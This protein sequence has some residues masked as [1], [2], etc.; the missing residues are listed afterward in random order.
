MTG[1][2]PSGAADLATLGLALL[3][4]FSALACAIT[5]IL[6]AEKADEGRR[7]KR[8]MEAA[9]MVPPGV[10]DPESGIPIHDSGIVIPPARRVRERYAYAVSID[11]EAAS[12][13]E[14]LDAVLSALPLHYEDSNGVT[15]TDVAHRLGLDKANRVTG[16]LGRLTD[17]G[18]ARAHNDK[19]NRRRRVYWRTG[20]NR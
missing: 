1:T 19:A 13:Q 3:V 6:L 7:F 2:D 5:R 12:P 10:E 14:R 15:A 9:V 11:W 4:I 20:S 8:G 18:L 16:T 17:A